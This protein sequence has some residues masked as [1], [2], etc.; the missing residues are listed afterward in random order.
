MLALSVSAV[1]LSAC[2][3]GG[4][5]GSTAPSTVNIPPTADAGADQS[6][7]EGTTVQLNGQGSDPDG[8]SV[9]FAWTQR[10]GP[11]VTFSDPTSAATTVDAPAVPILNADPAVLEFRVTDAQGS[12]STD[13]V[14]IDIASTDAV[15]YYAP[16]AVTRYHPDSA[17]ATVLSGPL[18]SG[19]EIITGTLSP[20]GQWFAYI[21]DQEIDDVAELYVAATDGSGNIKVSG[22]LQPEGDVAAPIRWSPD[23]AQIAYLADAVQDEANEVFVVDVDGTNHRKVSGSIG[24]PASVELSRISWSPDGRYL[25][26]VV[27]N[28][29]TGDYIG[30]NTYDSQNP[31]S[32]RIT[33]PA[34]ADEALHF[35]YSWVPDSSRLSYEIVFDDGVNPRNNQLFSVRPDG[36]DTILIT[37]YAASASILGYRYARDASRMA[38]IRNVPGGLAEL[39]I[40]APDGSGDIG[41]VATPTDGAFISTVG[42]SPDSSRINYRSNV[43]SPSV[44]VHVVRADGTDNMQISAPMTPGGQASFIEWSAD[45]SRIAYVADA[46]T[47]GQRELFAVNVDGSNHTRVNGPLPT[48]GDVLSQPR[49]SPDSSRIYYSAEQDDEEITEIYT[50]RPDA[51]ENFK[52]NAALPAGVEASFATWSLDSS[53][54]TYSTITAGGRWALTLASATGT[55]QIALPGGDGSSIGY[56]TP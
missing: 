20:N 49:W 22:P 42:W 43:G 39:R 56:W 32:V 25:A 50:V 11:T 13:S 33:R 17:T 37:N 1:A 9:T 36:T 7:D 48:N 41:V 51:S 14:T 54:L 6:V 29:A 55:N 34:V 23:S 52:I 3:G 46:N 30:I 15:Y 35:R 5:G 8:G 28:L 18:V 40:S 38:Y 24:N 2:G 47:V 21:A 26:Q 27:S 53:A 4:G 31:G 19:G 44:D 12:S 10:S 45:S 16:A